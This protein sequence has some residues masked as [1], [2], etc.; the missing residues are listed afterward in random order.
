[1]LLAGHVC[2]LRAW[3]GHR[4]PCRN[5]RAGGPLGLVPGLM[6]RPV[7]LVADLPLGR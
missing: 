7:D 2:P 3:R 4:V 1:L 5:E 6:K